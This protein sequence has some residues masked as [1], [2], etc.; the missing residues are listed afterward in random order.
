MGN[1]SRKP[2]FSEK[3]NR[4]INDNST[5]AWNIISASKGT[6]FIAEISVKKNVSSEVNTYKLIIDENGNLMNISY[7]FCGNEITDLTFNTSL[8]SGNI[9][10][11][12]ITDNI[13]ENITI[14][15]YVTAY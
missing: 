6:K 4:E 9:E 10:L 13:G 5:D 15:G 1:S 11:E 2:I 8:N 7:E 14:S 12:V 3:I